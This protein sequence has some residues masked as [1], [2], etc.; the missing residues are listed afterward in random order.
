MKSAIAE[1]IKKCKNDR[2]SNS[3]VMCEHIIMVQK[4]CC[5]VATMCHQSVWMI[6][7]QLVNWPAS[8]EDSV[9]L[10]MVF[11]VLKFHSSCG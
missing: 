11:F 10:M 3:S 6:F 1:A 8:E 9:F 7:L 4:R 2:E 5:T